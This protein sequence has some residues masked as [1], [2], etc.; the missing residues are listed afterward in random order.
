MWR[1]AFV[2]VCV[3]A[4][5]Y[6]CI[7]VCVQGWG[8]GVKWAMGQT[9]ITFANLQVAFILINLHG[10]LIVKNDL[11]ILSGALLFSLF[12]NLFFLFSFFLLIYKCCVANRK[13]NKWLLNNITYWTCHNYCQQTGRSLRNSAR[14]MSC[15]STLSCSSVHSG[16][17]CPAASRQIMLVHL[18]P[19]R[20]KP[21]CTDIG[22]AHAG[23]VCMRRL[24][25]HRYWQCACWF[26][27]HVQAGSGW[28]GTSSCLWTKSLS[29][30]KS[31]V[32]K[33]TILLLITRLECR[34]RWDRRLASCRISRTPRCFFMVCAHA[35]VP[36]GVCVWEKESVYV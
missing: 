19:Q 22:N 35:R 1:C 23:S 17:G 8:E 4:C 11:S 27:L 9:L 15:F 36:M 6:E 31:F 7:C 3:H 5:V 28:T 16:F 30:W 20:V 13:G 33:A 29:H 2:C 34:C 18:A 26:C 24:G 10:W 25:V 32:G 21:L 12:A 14:L